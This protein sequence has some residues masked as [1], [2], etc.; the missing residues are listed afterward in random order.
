MNGGDVAA[1]AAVDTANPLQS[2]VADDMPVDVPNW[3]FAESVPGAVIDLSEDSRPSS[4]GNNIINTATPK[5]TQIPAQ[6]PFPQTSTTQH[7]PPMAWGT[8]ASK[9][10]KGSQSQQQTGTS[11]AGYELL[12]L[13]MFEALPPSQM[14]EEL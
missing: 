4:G 1:P 5:A 8:M 11:T 7:A 13:G 2:H 9:P 6:V 10:N 14:I 12:G 3:D